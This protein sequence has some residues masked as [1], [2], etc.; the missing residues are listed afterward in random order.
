MSTLMKPTDR[1]RQR[2][3]K[4]AIRTYRDGKQ[5]KESYLDAEETF[6]K[7]SSMLT[8]LWKHEV[9]KG[10]STLLDEVIET[11][12]AFIMSKGAERCFPSQ[13][14]WRR[15]LEAH[16]EL[17]K[18]AKS[19]NPGRFTEHDV[20]LYI[21]II[22][23]WR[24]ELLAQDYDPSGIAEAGIVALAEL[25]STNFYAYEKSANADL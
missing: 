10:P 24:D 11:S 15:F 18:V 7:V 19:Y 5:P 6:L 13:E 4:A 8:H 2:T 22:G 3:Q 14:H 12:R 17:E 20:I 1:V 16:H 25:M 23:L 9:Y 21:E